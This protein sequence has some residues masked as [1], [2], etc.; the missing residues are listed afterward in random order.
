MDV[1]NEPFGPCA[2]PSDP[3]RARQ[4][5]LHHPPAFS[6]SSTQASGAGRRQPV[7]HS[8]AQ[9][10]NGHPAQRT[11]VP[12]LSDGEQIQHRR[13]AAVIRFTT[14]H[15][16]RQRARFCRSRSADRRPPALL[17]RSA[18]ASAALQIEAVQGN[19]EIIVKRSTPVRRVPGISGATYWAMAGWWWCWNW[20]RLV[21]IS[22]SQAQKQAESRA[23]RAARQEARP[24]KL[25]VMVITIRSPCAR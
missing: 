9:Q 1:V 25:S 5:P 8:A 22:A 21:P 7:R 24:E 2:A 10:S 19:Q 18:E 6:L 13:A 14:G 15:S 16:G 4:H 23:L 11:G 12:V 3:D 20:R 17:F